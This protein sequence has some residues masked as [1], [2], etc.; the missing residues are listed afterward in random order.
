MRE[1]VVKLSGPTVK[2]DR[3]IARMGRSRELIWDSVRLAGFP[4][5]LG[6]TDVPE[7]DPFLSLLTRAHGKNCN[8]HGDPAHAHA[9]T[10]SDTHVVGNH[11]YLLHATH[12]DIF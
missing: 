8:V 12:P 10:P 6:S 2:R 9:H 3:F 1:C 5:V 11:T 7:E 4:L